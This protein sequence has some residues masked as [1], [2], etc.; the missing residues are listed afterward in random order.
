M[1]EK[2]AFQLGTRAFH[3]GINVPIFD[4]ELMKHLSPVVGE[5]AK[6]FKAWDKG[7][8][9]E[10]LKEGSEF[11]SNPS[12]SEL[13]QQ[14]IHVRVL[15]YD[16]DFTVRA[17][18]RKEVD[19]IEKA[20]ARKA[21]KQNPSQAEVADE[22]FK[23]FHG[24]PSVRIT[25]DVIDW[26]PPAELEGEFGP[27]LAL[28]EH[29]ALLGNLVSLAYEDEET[30]DDEVYEFNKPYPLLCSDYLL[31]EAGEESLLIVGG[32]YH[33]H[34]IPGL[35][36]GLLTYVEYE[37]EKSFDDLKLV[38]YKHRFNYPAPVVAQNKKATQ[39]YIF[40]G[41]SEYFIAR[42]GEVSAGIDG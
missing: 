4:Q 23:K 34:K 29:V 38:T 36:C 5:N 33:V 11:V 42:D 18:A 41:D 15:L 6:M 7:W 3:K 22:S 19:R 12:K 20:I 14:L 2:E 16:N 32:D 25:T 9:T 13:E 24:K 1:N 21:K 30:L 17:M 39:L 35:V 31:E 10:N 28:P 8:A 37:A 26:P 27:F 40:R